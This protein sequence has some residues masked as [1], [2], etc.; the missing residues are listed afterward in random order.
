MQVTQIILHS[1]SIF[2]LV[3]YQNGVYMGP[4]LIIMETLFKNLT[5]ANNAQ[6]ELI[7]PNASQWNMVQWVREGWV[8][9]GHVHFMLFVSCSLALGSQHEHKF[10]VEYGLIA[11]AAPKQRKSSYSVI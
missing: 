5:Q 10:L 11:L 6:R 7:I 1:Y 3:F 9:V 4:C 2:F 8:C